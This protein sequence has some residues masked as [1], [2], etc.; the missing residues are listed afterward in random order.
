MFSESTVEFFQQRW[1]SKH[2]DVS[3]EALQMNSMSQAAR[4]QEILEGLGEGQ[5][6]LWKKNGDVGEKERYQVTWK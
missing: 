4:G 5:K 1:T 6:Q 2:S 3:C